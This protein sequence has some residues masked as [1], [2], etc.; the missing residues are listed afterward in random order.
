MQS[1]DLRNPWIVLRK[2]AINTTAQL[3]LVLDND[4]A[5]RSYSVRRVCLSTKTLA[6]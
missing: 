5:L 3:I 1:T 6:G 2:V 4:N